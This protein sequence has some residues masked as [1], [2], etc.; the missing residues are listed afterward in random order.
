MVGGQ[1]FCAN[2]ELNVLQ[3]IVVGA[4]HFGQDKIHGGGDESGQ[5]FQAYVQSPTPAEPVGLED[6]IHFTK[7]MGQVQPIRLE[8][9]VRELDRAPEI[10]MSVGEFQLRKR[11]NAVN[12]L[13]GVEICRRR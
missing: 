2:Q 6:D 12:V 11:Q 4:G 3:I 7:Q 1:G 5:P 13:S 10:L 9:R 8:F